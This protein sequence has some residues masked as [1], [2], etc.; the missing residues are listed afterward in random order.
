MSYVNV[1]LADAPVHYWRLADPGGLLFQDIGSTPRALQAGVNGLSGFTPYTGPTGDGGAAFLGLNNILNYND[2][3]VTLTLPISLECWYWIHHFVGSAIGF[4][5]VSDGTTPIEI[6]VDASLRPHAFPTGAAI[7]AVAATDRQHWHHMVLTNTAL[8]SNLYV[9]GVN[10]GGG[11][12]AAIAGAWHPS[13]VVG[14]GGTA[15]GPTRF[16]NAAIADVALY[17]VALSAAQVSAHFAAATATAQRPTFRGGGTFDTSGGLATL[18]S[19]S[20]ASVLASVRK[21]Y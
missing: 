5:G 18:D 15:A 8:A 3:D 2:S 20:L 21:V 10:V 19:T 6:G 1:V 17:Q 14:A 16:G 13:Y 12:A 11:V 4:F 7:T 9:D